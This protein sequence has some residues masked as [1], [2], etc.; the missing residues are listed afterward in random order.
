MDIT[1]SILSA[2]QVQITDFEIR[3]Q[4]SFQPALGMQQFTHPE[5]GLAVESPVAGRPVSD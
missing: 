2:V 3:E 4:G 1:A 5:A